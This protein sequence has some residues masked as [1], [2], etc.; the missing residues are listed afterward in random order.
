MS[1]E[2]TWLLKARGELNQE[3]IPGDANNLEILLYHSVTTGSAMADEVPWCS[4][5]VSWCLPD[6]G[7][8]SAWAKSYLR[9]GSELKEPKLGCIVVLS[10]GENSGHVGFYMGEAPGNKILLLGGNQ[11]N[12]VCTQAYDKSRVLSYR[13]PQLQNPTVATPTEGTGASEPAT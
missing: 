6:H 7:T 4:S 9:Y 2:P 11:S 1:L 12:K 10:R 13:W 3:E 8:K 5:F